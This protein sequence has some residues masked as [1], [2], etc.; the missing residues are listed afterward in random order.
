M[1]ARRPATPGDNGIPGSLQCDA[2]GNLFTS[3]VGS[4]PSG[5]AVI[6]AISPPDATPID[7]TDDTALEVAALNYVFDSGAG[8][9]IPEETT[10]PT[11]IN[12]QVNSAPA[13]NTIATATRA[14]PGAGQRNV[15]NSISAS[16]AGAGV[17]TVALVVRVRDGA[18]GTIVWQYSLS[19]SSTSA[20]QGV[21]ISG[22]EIELT[23]NTAAVIE[24]SAI[25][26]ALN[27]ESVSMTGI[28]RAV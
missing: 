24:F 20:S 13:V 7:P 15:V 23:A 18:G 25:P 9:W 17:S 10:T 21:S 27:Y 6:T 11:V 22:L 19:I 2:S 14:A 4:G 26:G 12:W 1:M 3:V 8:Q 28:A 5:P 16:L